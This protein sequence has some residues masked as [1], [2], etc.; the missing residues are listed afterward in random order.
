[1]AVNLAQAPVLYTTLYNAQPT[2]S[3]ATLYTS[4]TGNGVKKILAVN[5]TGSAATVSLTLVRKGGTATDSEAIVIANAFS[6][7]AGDTAD[8]LPSEELHSSLSELLME[9]GDYLYGEVGTGSSI[10]LMVYGT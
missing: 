8:L 9:A 10:Y 7:P 3:N 5:G 6:V 4:S 1:M 2:T